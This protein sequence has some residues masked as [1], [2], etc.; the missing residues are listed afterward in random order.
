M[1]T[2]EHREKIEWLS[3]YT[4]LLFLLDC[5]LLERNNWRG[6]IINIAPS[7][8]DLPKKSGVNDKI[9]EGISIILDIESGLNEEIKAI[10]EEREKIKT[11]IESVDNTV[12]KSLL[13]M[14][15]L[16]N[17]KWEEITYLCNYGWTHTHRLHE[18]ALDCIVIKNME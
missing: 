9:S 12:Y 5:K 17:Q 7:H 13:T 2:K 3:E 8:S 18:K 15:Y 10:Q 14:R 11:A 1:L 4:P 6:R 16:N